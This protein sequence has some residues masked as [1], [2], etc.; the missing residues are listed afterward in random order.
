MQWIYMKIISIK[1]LDPLCLNY[2]MYHTSGMILHKFGDII[3][4]EHIN[5]M[6][7]CGIESI[8]L[9]EDS[10][11]KEAC[12][13]ELKFSTLD[14]KDIEIGSNLPVSL[15]EL[16][17]KPFIE[18]G[19]F[20]TEKV[21]NDLKTRNISKLL[22]EKDECELQ[23]FQYVKYTSLIYNSYDELITD[24]RPLIHPRDSID[25]YDQKL[26]KKI[27]KIFD[28]SNITLDKATMIDM[29]SRLVTSTTFEARWGTPSEVRFL[30]NNQG[31]Q[32]RIVHKHAIRESFEKKLLV[33]MYNYWIQKIFEFQKDMK[34]MP[35]V[36]FRKIES[37]SKEIAETYCN[38]SWFVLGMLN[39]RVAAESEL[40]IANKTINTSILTAAITAT[41]GYA[42]EQ[43]IESVCGALLYD[44]GHI[45][46]S[47]YLFTKDTLTSSEQSRFDQ[48]LNNGI[49]L[50]KKIGLV[51][52]SV[53][54]VTYQH[55]EYING[56]GSLKCNARTMH[57]LAKIICIA[58][59][60]EI[61]C[62]S[63]SPAESMSNLL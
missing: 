19:T 8:V 47:R 52:R 40:Y 43:I 56:S 11:N 59:Q 33:G 6:Y 61:Y 23:T 1:D 18:S 13:N 48:H 31:I 44:I 22:Y 5:L 21:L 58:D 10:D 41:G 25:Q 20:I 27:D 54:Y 30:P 51:P 62:L 53:P 12:L 55:H 32:N 7:E 2:D 49:A 46:T 35:S 4:L 42:S 57:D 17:G 39:Q 16:N 63:L 38:D 28:F 36:S 60:Y 9:I 14:I 45:I 34:N 24:L 26:A 50:L 3:K 37:L 29:S 15:F